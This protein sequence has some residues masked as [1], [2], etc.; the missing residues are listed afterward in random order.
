[1]T[2]HTWDSQAFLLPDTPPR[3]NTFHNTK[4]P[5]PLKDAM[6]SKFSIPHYTLVAAES[7]GFLSTS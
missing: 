5:A 4:P 3:W 2:F 1:V 7:M 6:R